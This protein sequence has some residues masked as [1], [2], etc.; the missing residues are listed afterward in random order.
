MKLI[1]CDQN[2]AEVG[3]AYQHCG[4][5]KPCVTF[6]AAPASDQ[7]CVESDSSPKCHRVLR[8]P[9]QAVVS[10][11]ALI[12]L[13]PVSTSNTRWPK[14]QCKIAS[15]PHAEISHF[16]HSVK[17]SIQWLQEKAVLHSI[18]LAK[19]PWCRYWFCIAPNCQ[20]PSNNC[21]SVEINYEVGQSSVFC[22]TSGINPI[23]GRPS[24]VP[25]ASH[26]T[27]SDGCWV[28][29]TRCYGFSQ[30][31]WPEQVFRTEIF[32]M[33]FSLYGQKVFLPQIL[34]CTNEQLLTHHFLYE[35]PTHKPGGWSKRSQLNSGSGCDGESTLCPVS[36]TE[37]SQ[38][39]VGR[40][41][42]AAIKSS[43]K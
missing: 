13:I 43:G 4:W 39:P 40:T 34:M 32:R 41:H 21:S 35:N 18:P 19:E 20:I 11:A 36:P 25:R 31:Q 29:G 10:V 33:F 15:W 42:G 37:H 12:F 1:Y 5:I 28:R 30:K 2:N 26:E 7:G 38:T 9:F 22:P 24:T 6:I 8:T 27:D 16:E 17:N 3:L 23:H 14:S